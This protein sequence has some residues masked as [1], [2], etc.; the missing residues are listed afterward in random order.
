[1]QQRTADQQ[2][3][4]NGCRHSIAI[5]QIIETDLAVRNQD[6]QQTNQEDDNPRIIISMPERSAGSPSE[7]VA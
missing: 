7:P 4:A 2:D 3:C 6:G 5:H 1:L